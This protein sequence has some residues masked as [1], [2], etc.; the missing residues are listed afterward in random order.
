M[1]NVS[2]FYTVQEE[3]SAVG[4]SD[5]ALL[6]DAQDESVLGLREATVPPFGLDTMT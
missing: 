2:F 6:P 3:C 5:P 1:V 4:V